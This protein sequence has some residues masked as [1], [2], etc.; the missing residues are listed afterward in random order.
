MLADPRSERFARHFVRQWLD[1]SLLDFLHV[2][3]K[4]YPTFDDDLKD[5]MAEEPVAFFRELLQE[6]LSVLAFLHADFTLADERLAAHYGLEGVLGN[7]FRRVP[8]GA[9]PSRGGLLAQAGL[10]AMNSDGKD[11]HPLKRGVWLLE[12]LLDDP[13]PP[14]PP[15]VPTIDLT[16]PEI[17]KLTL[18]QRIEDHRDDPACMSCHAKIDP[19]GIA[20]E[21]FDAAG[22]WRSELNGAPVDATSVLFNGQVLEGLDGLKRFLLEHRQDQFVHAM[23]V[24]LTAFAL[25][26]PVSFEDRAAIDGITAEVRR[27]GDGLAT[28]VTLIATSEL[29]RAR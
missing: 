23:V 1:L 13:P 28:M 6:D 9:Q 17:A 4:V 24:K 10:L 29:L 26:R 12:R 18:K 3:R 15:A 11:S 16:D 27:R 22:S 2:D 21:Q 8:I 14:P 7:H 20:F 25:G 5:A 19:W